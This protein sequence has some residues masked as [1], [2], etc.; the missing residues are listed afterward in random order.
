MVKQHATRNMELIGAVSVHVGTVEAVADE[1]IMLSEHYS[2]EGRNAGH[3]Y[4]IDLRLATT[5]EGAQIRLW[6][7]ADVALTS[8]EE[9][10]R[11]PA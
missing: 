4:F 9:E 2:G 7:T 11:K 5:V 3:T 1:C 6:A 10:S 8:E